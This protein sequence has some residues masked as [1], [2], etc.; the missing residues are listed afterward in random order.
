MARVEKKRKPEAAPK[1]PMELFMHEHLAALSVRG[2][3]TRHLPKPARRRK[4][5]QI[6]FYWLR[7]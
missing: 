3:A 4:G 6:R 5:T 1:T 2:Y 7:F